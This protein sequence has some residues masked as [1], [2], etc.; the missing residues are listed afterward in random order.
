LKSDPEKVRAINKMPAPTD[1]DGI[2]HFLGTVNYLDKFINHKADLQG[3]VS[4]PT[5]KDTAFD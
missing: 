4:Q 1:K 3:L 2:L 5:G